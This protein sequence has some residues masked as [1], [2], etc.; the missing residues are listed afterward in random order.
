M[1]KYCNGC[2]R[3]LENNILHSYK[4]STCKECVNKKVKR[5]FCD[6]E[7]NRYNLS[8]HVKQIHS[9]HKSSRT[10]DTAYDSSGTNDSTSD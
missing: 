7:L 5:D 3:G 4:N 10:T 2:K 1:L 6:R 8:K 9:T